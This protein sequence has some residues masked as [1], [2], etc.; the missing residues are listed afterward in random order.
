M[1][2]KY[3]F[4]IALGVALAALVLA[5]AG[6]AAKAQATPTACV[7][8]PHN[9]TITVDETWCL[10]D[11][12]HLLAGNVTV[13]AG[14]TLTI[15]PGVT[16][17][18]AGVGLIVQGHLQAAGSA[19]QP[20]IFTSQAD[21][22]ARQWSGIAFQGGA[23]LLRYAV[24]RNSG[25]GCY[26]CPG[27]Y[28]AGV[29]ALNVQTGAVTI[30][31]SQIITSAGGTHDT[32]LYVGNSRV[33]VSDTY[34]SGIGDSATER[35]FPVY[36]SGAA[37]NV[38]LSG[39]RLQNNIYNQVALTYDAMTGHDFTLAAQPEMDSYRLLRGDY[40]D[41]FVVP[42]GVTMTVEQGVMVRVGDINDPWA[43]LIVRGR[44]EAAGS[45]GAPIVFTSPWDSGAYQWAGITFDG[46]AGLLRHAIVRNSGTGSYGCPGYSAGVAALNVQTGMVT[47][48][49]SQVITSAGG[50]NSNTGLYVANSRVVVSDALF[51]GIG[52]DPTQND[53]PV[54]I[55]GATSDVSLSGLRLEN[56]LYN[57]IAFAPDVIA[58]RDLTL[59]AQPAGGYRLLG[60]ATI[61][62]GRTLTVEPG[63]KVHIG[64]NDGAYPLLVRGR[65][66]AAGT[67]TQPITFTSPT[68]SGADYADWS[69][70]A[71]DGGAG[72]LRHVTVRYTGDECYGCSIYQSAPIRALNVL[73]GAV[74]IESSQV[75]HAYRPGHAQWGI[76][77]ENSHVVVSDTLISGLNNM[78]TNAPIYFSGNVRS[79]TLVGNRLEGNS[80][81][82]I[83]F[84]PQATLVETMTWQP[85]A[86][87]QGYEL[88][89]EDF[90]VASGATLTVA[91]GTT[92]MAPRAGELYVQGHLQAVGTP[93]QPILF[94]SLTNTG[95]DQWAGLS[96]DGGSGLIRYASVRYA[97][98]PN[99]IPPAA[100]PGYYE[101]WHIG[102][103]GAIAARNVL[104]G[105]LRLE[106]VNILQN[107]YGWEWRPDVAVRLYNSHVVIADSLIADNGSPNARVSMLPETNFTIFAYGPAT[108]LTLTHNTFERNR[109][110]SVLAEGQFTLDANLFRDSRKGIKVHPN[111]GAQ[112][113]NNALIDLAGD[114]LR[115]V[116][117]AQLAAWHTTLARNAGNALYV[118]N[119]ATA[120][121]ANTILAENQTGVRVTGSGA[122]TLAQTLWDRN[123]TPTVGTVN[124]TG[125]IDGPAGFDW[126]GFHLTR[127]SAAL[128]RAIQTGVAHDIDGDV[129]PTP[130]GTSP[131]L[132]ADEHLFTPTSDLIAGKWA[133]APKGIVTVDGNTGAINF[134]VWQHYL[135]RFFHGMEDPEPLHVTITD[136]LPDPL[137]LD[138]ETHNPAMNFV[139]QGQSLQWQTIAPLAVNEAA[140]VH[141]STVGHP[142]PGEV[143]ENRATLMAGGHRFDLGVE[144]VTPFYPPLI[145]S[146]GDGEYCYSNDVVNVSGVALGNALIRVFENGVE[147]NTTTSDAHGVFT[148]TYQ[149]LHAQE[150]ITVTTKACSLSNPNQCSGE[151]EAAHLLPATSFWDP[152]RSYWEGTPTTGPLAGQHLVFR[153]RDADSGLF[154]AHDWVIP[155]VFGF[156]NTHL[157]LYVCENTQPRVQADGE[158]YTGHWEEDYWVYEIEFAH[159]VN[160]CD[161]DYLRCTHGNVEIDPDGYVFD[162]TQGF[163]P[164]NPTL[165]AL[166]GITVTCMISAP[167]WGGWVPWPAHLYNNQVNP[168]VTDDDGYFAFFTPPGDYYLQVEGK[169]GYQSWR[170]PVI[171]VVN[172]I[173]HVNVPL[174]PWTDG[175]V[176][177]V[178]LDPTGPGPATLNVPVGGV[179]EWRAP[180]DNQA[181]PEPQ[182]AL[183]ENP[184][185]HLLSARNPLS[186]TLGFDGGMLAPGQ[187][188]RRQFTAPGTYTYSDGLGHTATIT[189]TGAETKLYLP[190]V[191]R[192][193]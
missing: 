105:E 4:L 152:Q 54:Y 91:P 19:A 47:I 168:Q 164:N 92:V 98:Y 111:V 30:E 93:A 60:A 193:R 127:F 104:T 123:T 135:L 100:L 79:A 179:V 101:A 62:A 157:H 11:S 108:Q 44:L 158:W 150:P 173:V 69:G 139:A 41:Q 48:E 107:G 87:D 186:D 29:A 88:D 188:Y 191:A 129:R 140:E 176:A 49:A 106:H 73:D 10:A 175:T 42:Q 125:H 154:A 172:E 7:P 187:V 115:L 59:N 183:V 36:I 128:E 1:K 57:Q 121:F 82:R 76:W 102:D 51:S 18:A 110:L 145:T 177:Q 192:N 5:G 126:D 56:N 63:V 86:A 17:Q 90:I 39:L 184:T 67:A 138:Y 26:G 15:E 144:T 50:P 134:A 116:P 133:F 131:D 156:W 170:S 8:G 28:S 14:A 70:I 81:D 124:E 155:G 165:H 130:A 75:I 12:P 83:V 6:S 169:P 174:T 35:D 97:G 112:F 117:N 185:V 37:S 71:F 142:Q 103:S 68:D 85:Q 31:S 2:T 181:P 52:D 178:T 65:L 45:A 120:T 146:I 113:T 84:G 34:F 23:G 24:V 143:L 132:G 141:I 89:N 149:S 40:G 163:D 43:P 148:S 72:T 94:T 167:R 190:L 53:F 16:V 22:G 9:G 109:G 95:M 61:P 118:E 13:A 46:G 114:A 3:T 171:H 25:Y 159:D 182:L 21:S 122:A 38:S 20:I 33:V 74:T 160:I 151:S 161:V 136:E 147:V 80:R 66:E 162:V 99:R 64:N 180:W 137:T 78:P 55:T 166:S 77:V 153:F 119:G 32:G 58:G 96:F 189:V 27:G